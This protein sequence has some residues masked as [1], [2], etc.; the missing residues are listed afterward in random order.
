MLKRSFL[1]RTRQLWKLNIALVVMAIGLFIV[2]GVVNGTLPAEGMAVVAG[3]S[4]GLAGM[5]WLFL[6]IRCPNCHDRVLW[7]AARTRGAG[8]WL[9][10]LLQESTC[11]SCGFDTVDT[12]IKDDS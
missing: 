7:K 11:P 6:S 12:I 9:G 2:F 3:L 4:L 8:N 5:G 1:A 10:R